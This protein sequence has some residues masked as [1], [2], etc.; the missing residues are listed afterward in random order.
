MRRCGV[1]GN[2]VKTPKRD[3]HGRSEPVDLGRLQLRRDGGEPLYRQLAD[4][5]GALI[6]DG[7]LGEGDRL[8]PHRELARA[9]SI[10]I[11]TVTRAIALLKERG[12]V[13]GRTG[14]GTLVGPPDPLTAAR[15]RSVPATDS[16]V[17]DLSVNR[18]ATDGYVSALARLLKEILRDPRYREVQDYQAAEGPGWAREA[19]ADWL[20]GLGVAA[21][22][23]CVV[24]AAGAQHALTIV[25]RAM[26]RPGDVVIAD[27]VSYQGLSASCRMLELELHTLVGDTRGMDP[28]ELEEVCR[29]QRPRALFLVPSLH[30]PTT[31]TLDE[32]RRRELVEVARRHDLLIIEDD[33]YRPLL[34]VAPPSLC[35]LAP[36]RTLYLSSFSKCIAPGLRFG[37]AL[38]P[39]GCVEDVTTALRVD[40]W[41]VDALA[42][43][44]G[45]RLI[46]SGETGRIL[47]LQKSE[48]RSRHEILLATI[49]ADRVSA[50]PTSTHAWLR[51][52]EPW[53]GS[54]FTQACRRRG[55]VVLP[56]EAFTSRQAAAPHAVRI[57]LAAA[58]SQ[59]ALRQ[60][61]QVIADLL[62]SGHRHVGTSV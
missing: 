46:E 49:P 22:P 61:L 27:S 10:N 38:V 56:G 13:S 33:V 24:L 31:V 8:P 14:G 57:N 15:F 3:R 44:I 62:E 19:F 34:D 23:Q 60:A 17:I 12:L 29:E 41:S 43:F 25:L 37:A 47:E 32:S 58:R 26:L 51:L 45:T 42:S 11:T 48:L 5:I 7:R 59:S 54:D 39:S 50:V 18:P 40:C 53:R 36:E 20:G 30:N 52:P 21:D 55:V 4:A 9:L 28:A 1:Q 6:D 35:E 16:E 2:A